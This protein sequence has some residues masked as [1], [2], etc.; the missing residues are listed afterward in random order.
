MVARIEIELCNPLKRGKFDEIIIHLHKDNELYSTNINFDF[1]PLYSFARDK[2]SIAFDFLMFSVLIYNIDRFVNRNIF[3]LE[4]WTREIEV[5]N[6]PVIHIVEFLRVKKQMDNAISFLT[7]DYWNINYCQSEGSLYHAR[8]DIKD[9][10]DLSV[11]NKVCLFSGGLDSLIGAIDELES[12]Q[13]K[14]LLISHKDLGKEGSDQDSIMTLFNQQHLYENKYD[15]IQTSVGIGKKVIDNKIA[16]EA[17]FRSRSLLFIGMGIYAAYRIGRDIP[18]II[19]ENGTIALNIPL[20]SSRRSACS[21]RTTHPTFLSLLQNILSEISIFNSMYNPY[22]LKTK[23]E[24]VDNSQNSIVLQQLI[25]TS[26]S[27]AKR[28]HNYYWDADP[29]TIIQSNIRHC[30]MCLPCI[31]RRVSLHMN[32]LDQNANLHYGTDIFNGIKY[33]ITNKEQKSTRDFR[34]LLE[35]IKNRPTID[36]IEKELLINGVRDVSK[37]HEY[38]LVVDRTINQIIDWIRASGNQEIKR[39]AGI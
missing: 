6:M 18:L 32:N 29:Q 13:N 21:T 38:A 11:Y 4:G 15:Q 31:Y 30:G 23:G 26:C 8:A 19:P 39:K 10:G 22:E 33:D 5:T 28:G 2:E 3:S 24:M 20:M 12:Q 34:T 16:R 1:N 35:F 37:L 27:C 36:R 9:W 14:L 7:G 17:T 25:H